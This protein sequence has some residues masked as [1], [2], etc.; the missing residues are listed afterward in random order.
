MSLAF[1]WTVS[2]ELE[3]LEDYRNLAEIFPFLS[4][5]VDQKTFFV[6]D[7]ETNCIKFLDSS[8]FQGWTRDQRSV[9]AYSQGKKYGK[10]VE[11]Y[12]NG[13]KAAEGTYSQDEREGWW[14][15]WMDNV[16]HLKSSEG[17]YVKGK[18]YG[19]WSYTITAPAQ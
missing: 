18:K 1:I 16:Q 14:V 6:K 9:G 15:L 17:N 13:Q 3:T 10:W 7:Q 19:L 5:L 11:R 2:L 4:S 8:V 12:D